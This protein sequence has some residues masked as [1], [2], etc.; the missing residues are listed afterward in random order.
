MFET[1]LRNILRAQAEFDFELA[2]TYDV[3]RLSYLV[4]THIEK[5]ENYRMDVENMVD[6]LEGE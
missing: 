2:R 5:L 4:N 6:E 3:Y 1:L